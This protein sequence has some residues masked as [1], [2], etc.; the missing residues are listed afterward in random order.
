MEFM[1]EKSNTGYQSFSDV[2]NYL[3]LKYVSIK[4]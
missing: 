2:N 3:T 1:K 4:F